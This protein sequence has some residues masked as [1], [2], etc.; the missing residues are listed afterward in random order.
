MITMGGGGGGHL[1]FQ[2]SYALSLL[3]TLK[4]PSQLH[5]AANKGEGVLMTTPQPSTHRL[6]LRARNPPIAKYRPN[7]DVL[8]R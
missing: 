1:C 5:D 6:W 8:L 3:L 2:L 4:V 7:S